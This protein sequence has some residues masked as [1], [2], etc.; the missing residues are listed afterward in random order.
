MKLGKE[1]LIVGNPNSGKSTLFNLLTGVKQ[2]TG[3]YP[4]ITTEKK[5]ATLTVG[6]NS[7][8][9]VDLPGIYSL[10]AR[11]EDERVSVDVIKEKSESGIIYVADAMNLK[12]SLL[13]FS[14]LPRDQKKMLIVNKIDLAKSQG[15]SINSELLSSHLGCP[16]VLVNAKNNKNL[17]NEIFEWSRIEQD[18]SYSFQSDGIVQRFL[19]IDSLLQ[20]VQQKSVR[21]G[22]SKLD[23]LLV[24]R[25]WG[26]VIFCA[27][28]FV[29]FQSLFTLAEYPMAWIEQLFSLITDA[30]SALL[31]DGV[32]RGI[33]NEGVLP[34]L[35]GVVIFI[36]QIA[37]LFFFIGILEHTGYMSRAAHLMD[38]I[39]RKFGMNGK[40]VLPM[41]S[42]FACAVPAIMAT[43]TIEGWK[44]RLVTMFVLPFTTC[45][46]RLPVYVVLIE[47]F[48]PEETVWGVFDLKGLTMTAL[49]LLGIL[50]ALI[51]GF[52]MS[53]IVKFKSQDLFVF[54]LPKLGY[55]NW[56]DIFLGIWSK[57][58][59]FV[60]EAGRIIFILS[61]VL[62]FLG[63]YGPSERFTEIEERYQY[64]NIDAVEKERLI[65]SEKLEH[66]YLGIAGNLIEPVI[67]PLGYDWKIGISLIASFAAREVMVGT[68]AIIYSVGEEDEAS[69][70]EKIQNDSAKNANGNPKFGLA[71]AL[72]LLVFYAFA[73]QCM[74]TLAIMKRETGSWKWPLLQFV[75]MTSLAYLSALIIFQTLS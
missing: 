1:I 71:M 29:I 53:K 15:L 61:I 58:K 70:V 66:S 72:S 6:E 17:I 16:V 50:G 4:G 24:N 62:W 33:L 52:V 48:I 55:P 2:K 26:F 40:S 49:Y 27:I 69:L 63:S 12:R 51:V 21:S 45:A 36:P 42:G 39:M 23:A 74:S 59:T 67:K 43:R 34:G 19:E 44:Q 14:Q 18:E 10:K 65:A 11:T 20:N 30:T 22:M 75:F 38:G 35:E 47:A 68:L 60:L 3:N 56:R 5:S 64:E 13:L 46:A 32:L 73:L 31:P 41:V 7:F 8:N 37:L 57:T 28:L 9:L 54:E 25:F